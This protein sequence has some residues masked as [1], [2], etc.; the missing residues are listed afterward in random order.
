METIEFI[1]NY[2]KYLQEIGDVVKPHL[3][4]VIVELSEIDPHD[5]VEPETYFIS[6]SHARGFVWSLFLQ[7]VMKYTDNHPLS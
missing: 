4:S 3:I 6:P 1:T 2:P 5:L 7:R